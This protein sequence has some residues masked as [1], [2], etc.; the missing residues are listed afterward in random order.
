MDSILEQY[1]D[2]VSLCVKCGICQ[3]ECPT[4]IATGD[5]S[6]VARGRLAMIE[7]VLDGELKLTEGFADRISKCTS[8][9]SCVSNC[10][11]G[12]DPVKLINAAKG[13]YFNKNGSDFISKTFLNHF[14]RSGRSLYPLFKLLG[15]ANRMFYDHIPTEG[16][17]KEILPF[18]RDG[19]KKSLPLFGKRNLRKE[20]PEIIRVKNPKM[21]VVFFSGCMTDFVYPDTGHTIINILKA[22]N[23]ETI[24]PK[25]ILCCGAPAYYMGDQKTA[26]I[27]AEKN[28]NI[29]RE[30]NP[31]YIIINCAT[32]GEVLKS[33]YKI[34]LNQNGN[35][36]SLGEKV[37]DIHKFL[38]TAQCNID[39][40]P[41]NLTIPPSQ[42][43]NLI[44]P[45]C[46]GGQGGFSGRRNG[47]VNNNIPHYIGQLQKKLSS[48]NRIRVTYHDP[49]HLKRGQN[50]YSEPR[51]ILKS[52][53]WVDFVEMDDPDM[54]CGGA[55]G[56]NLR[57]Y[58]LSLEIGKRKA[59][60]IKR[61]E[62]DVV[63]TGCPSCQM[64]I[65]DVLNR[66]E[67]NRPVLHTIDLLN[68]TQ[69]V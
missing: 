12:I 51:E 37:I 62:A 13:E 67:Y 31:D 16:W 41:L 43:G 8:C 28:H 23:I 7:A 24:I 68:P 48:N 53:P 49:C 19:V 40:L 58:D 59:E 45:P 22:N 15:M 5:E 34:L 29:L 35:Y 69:W 1:Q 25:N 64:H 9:L 21:R 52:L 4:Y 65:M 60:N 61:T 33:V 46:K 3:S 30:L 55:G 18:V 17:L 39:N 56:F 27:L 42:R 44:S 57:H 66:A 54:C 32:C 38:L 10:P 14:A 11:R 50:V 47:M 6:M 26:L 2:E 36:S 20:V 63:A